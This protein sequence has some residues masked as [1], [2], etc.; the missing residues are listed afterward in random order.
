M[1]FKWYHLPLKMG[2]KNPVTSALQI[3]RVKVSTPNTPI[4]PPNNIENANMYFIKALFKNW[5]IK[6]PSPFGAGR[7]HINKENSIL[8]FR[9]QYTDKSKLYCDQCQLSAD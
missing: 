6:T 4:G 1:K 2:V 9:I 7:G 8:F 5:H 3:V